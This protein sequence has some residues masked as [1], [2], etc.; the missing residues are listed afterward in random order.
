MKIFIIQISSKGLIRIL[1]VPHW[2]MLSLFICNNFN[3]QN[4]NTHLLTYNI[5]MCWYYTRLPPQVLKKIVDC[6]W[7]ST[8]NVVICLPFLLHQRPH[9]TPPHSGPPNVLIS[10]MDVFKLDK[11]LIEMISR[12]QIFH[13]YDIRWNWKV[14]MYFAFRGLHEN[15]ISLWFHEKWFHIIVDDF[16]SAWR[17]S[18]HVKLD[19][20]YFS[21]WLSRQHKNA[22]M[23][24]HEMYW[25]NIMSSGKQP[26][27][28]VTST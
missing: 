7:W 15:V 24:C 12:T 18:F 14:H 9:P 17:E 5:P 3:T 23:K 4:S 8:V 6:G 22:S 11:C 1:C 16:N 28:W 13:M 19:D 26:V 20:V 27:Y 10:V 21:I 25:V 2:F